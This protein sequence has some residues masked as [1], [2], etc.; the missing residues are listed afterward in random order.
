MLASKRPG[1]LVKL[2]L[3]G[4]PLE[5]LIWWVHGRGLRMYIS[6]T[7]FPRSAMAAVREPLGE[8]LL[9]GNA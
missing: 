7:E 3:L 5:F 8:S 6:N 9:Q 4:P 1:G 2:R